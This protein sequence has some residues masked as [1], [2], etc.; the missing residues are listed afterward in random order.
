MVFTSIA[1]N[2]LHCRNLGPNAKLAAV[3]IQELCPQICNLLE[4]FGNN[5]L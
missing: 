2:V 1:D 4:D 3:F 5:P